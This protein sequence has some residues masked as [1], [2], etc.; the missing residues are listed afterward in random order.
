VT[1]LRARRLR[2]FGDDEQI[3]KLADLWR[4]AGRITKS[5]AI[6][7]MLMSNI[8]GGDMTIAKRLGWVFIGIVIGWIGSTSLVAAK[9]TQGAPPRR[10][11]V[12]AGSKLSEGVNGDFIKDTSLVN[13]SSAPF[14][15]GDCHRTCRVDLILR[16]RGS[17]TDHTDANS[18]VS[19]QSWSRVRSGTVVCE[20][21]R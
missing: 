7:V 16:K 4:D 6:F 14:G 3:P 21:T 2:F 11:V 17:D 9:W 8:A 13:S 20:D 15:C 1:Q 5:Q 10:L 18:T 12:V 19:A